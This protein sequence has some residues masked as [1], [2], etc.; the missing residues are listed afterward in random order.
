MQKQILLEEF[1]IGVAQSMFTYLKT[2]TNSLEPKKKKQLAALLRNNLRKIKRVIKPPEK[3]LPDL[4]TEP[5]VSIFS[6][7]RES[8]T[9]ELRRKEREE[10]F[11]E[12]KS[13]TIK[14]NPVVQVV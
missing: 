10:K 5:K 8:F 13:T 6:Q 12:N 14:I 11:K 1:F 7:K 3:K 9:N 2:Q 4:F